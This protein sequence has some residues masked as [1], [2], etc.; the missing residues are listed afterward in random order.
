MRWTTNTTTMRQRRRRASPQPDSSYDVA[1][2]RRGLGPREQEQR[3][4]RA[5]RGYISYESTQNSSSS[6]WARMLG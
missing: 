5:S 3:T 6:C 1:V 4:Q 2:D